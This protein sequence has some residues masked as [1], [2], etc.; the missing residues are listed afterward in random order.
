[1]EAR[2]S[3][4]VPTGVI[5]LKK[6]ML[7]PI[8]PA[9]FSVI[10]VSDAEREREKTCPQFPDWPSFWL[11]LVSDFTSTCS[12]ANQA[13]SVRIEPTPHENEAKSMAPRLV[14]VAP[15]CLVMYV[16]TRTWYY[17]VSICMRH[18]ILRENS[19]TLRR[20]DGV[21]TRQHTS[22]N[23]NNRTHTRGP[24]P[25]LTDVLTRGVPSYNTKN[26]SK[27]CAYIFYK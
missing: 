18:R 26:I 15:V 25:Q 19:F 8:L 13:N 3:I 10:I 17:S 1:M 16:R 4:F 27:T 5:P 7:P 14:C 23:K 6:R 12:I 20:V 24:N 2:V 9:V 22:T 21:D 11:L